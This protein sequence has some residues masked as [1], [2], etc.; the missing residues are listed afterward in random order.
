MLDKRAVGVNR[1]SIY[2][3][4]ADRPLDLSNRMHRRDSLPRR[5]RRQQRVSIPWDC[6]F[7]SLLVRL[8]VRREELPGA[9]VAGAREVMRVAGPPAAAP[10]LDLRYDD[11]LVRDAAAR[12]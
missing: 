6:F 8:V 7:S 11:D 2:G 5:R 4:G 9:R 12:A 3:G 10:N 1:S